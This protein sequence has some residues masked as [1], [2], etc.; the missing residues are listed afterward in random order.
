[1]IIVRLSGGLGNQMF[2]YAA[3]LSVATRNN[4]EL[5]LDLEYLNNNVVHN[6]FELNTIFN[7]SYMPSSD[8][9][10]KSIL[11]LRSNKWIFKS[12]LRLNFKFL[13]GSH[14]YVQ[15]YFSYDKKFNK[16]CDNNYLI[17]YFQ[18]EKY[19]SNIKD[20]IRK[21]FRFKKNLSK[22]NLHFLR[23]IKN[24]NSVS[25][26]VRRGDYVTNQKVSNIHRICSINYYKKAI[27]Y[28]KKNIENPH[29]YIFS[30]DKE[31]VIKNFNFERRSTII[32]LNLNKQNYV[33]MLLMSRCKH[34]IIA[35]SSFSWWG[36]WLNNNENKKTIAPSKWFGVANRDLITDDIYTNKMIKI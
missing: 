6:G 2:Q 29:F 35:N 24:T 21:H 31:W 33:D 20:L 13:T 3:G 22:K 36:S 5:F 34:N 12:L 15:P 18:S 17:G 10:I 1:M 16:I 14:L 27:S 7:I 23:L 28:I 30:D 4:A 11:G 26:H 8:N 32:S 25:I 9:Q 19:F